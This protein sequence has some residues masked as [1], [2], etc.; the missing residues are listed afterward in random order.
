MKPAELRNATWREVLTHI[1]DDMHRVADAWLQHGPGTTRQVA[2][3]SGISLLTFRPRTTDL[4][5]L[6]FVECIG[7]SGTEGIYRGRTT[8]EARTA[9][10]A[11]ERPD[12]TG[13]VVKVREKLE[14]QINTLPIKDQVSIA[15]GIMARAGHAKKHATPGAGAKQEELSLA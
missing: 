1:T 2:E 13:E 14:R 11:G 4:F 5:Q 9:W 6:G 3:K 10:E 7:A 12:A 15:A 8:D